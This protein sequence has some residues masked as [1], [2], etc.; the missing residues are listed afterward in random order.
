MLLPVPGVL[1]S[2]ELALVRAAL[3]RA[4]FVDGKL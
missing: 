2:D 1:K 4:R 3:E